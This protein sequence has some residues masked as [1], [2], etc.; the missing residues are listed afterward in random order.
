MESLDIDAKYGINNEQERNQWF[1][2]KIREQDCNYRSD[3]CKS[4]GGIMSQED[5]QFIDGPIL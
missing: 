1:L 5:E 2:N 4:C 3:H